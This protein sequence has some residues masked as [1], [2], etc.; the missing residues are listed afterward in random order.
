MIKNIWRYFWI[1]AMVCHIAL[2]DEAKS[3]ETN[4]LQNAL[5]QTAQEAKKR[6]EASDLLIG[7]VRADTGEVI[8]LAKGAPTLADFANYA[9]EPG[10]VIKPFIV[11]SYLEAQKDARKVA[12]AYLTVP[13]GALPLGKDR[14]VHVQDDGTWGR[15]QISE[16]LPAGSNKAVAALA[17][18]TDAQMLY[19]A[20][21]RYGFGTKSGFGGID[22]N[23]SLRDAKAYKHAVMRVALA[24]GYGLRAT[25]MQLLRA[26]AMFVNGGMS[27]QTHR[28]GAKTTPHRAMRKESATCL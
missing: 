26:Y 15:L 6:W 21:R 4:Q 3:N 27:V 11:S 14:R 24:N 25:P 7:I 23:G 19:D 9:Y 1:M 8:A 2:A 5:T 18:E 17:L 22:D 12:Q 10:G 28:G 20:L 16:I 13:R